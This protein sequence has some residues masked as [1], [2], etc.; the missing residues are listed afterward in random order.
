MS[1]E[2]ATNAVPAESVASAPPIPAAP[3]ASVRVWDPFVRA[4]H[5]LLVAGFLANYFELVRAGRY[6]HRAIG[7]VVLGLIGARLLWGFVGPR[8]ARF[9]DFVRHPSVILS[10]L[11]AITTRHDGRHLG[12]NPAGGAMII[13][14]LV[15][16]LLVGLTGWLSR[17]DWF[18]G[19]KWMEETHVAL[20]NAMFAMV[21]IHILGVVHGCWRHR[22]NLVLSM[23]T[24]RK[25]AN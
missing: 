23:L 24:G 4:F 13:A 3:A 25:R 12:H 8:H 21:C 14:L 1:A 22:E 9:V 15:A 5:W 20:V 16:T 11:K 18:F 2:G 17:T 10:H 6:S 19:I 7:Y